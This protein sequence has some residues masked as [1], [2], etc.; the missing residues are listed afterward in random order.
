M[1]RKL[2]IEDGVL[3]GFLH[4]TY[5]AKKGG[6]A[7]TGNAVR[8]G[9]NGLPT[10][11]ITN[12]YIEKGK[13]TRY[14]LTADISN[15]IYITDTMGIHT[16]NPISGDFSVGVSGFWIKNGVIVH[17]VREAVFS[18]NIFDMLQKINDIG[19]D[20][21]FYGRIGSPSISLS[22]MDISGQ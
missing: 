11:G 1:R 12:F 22:E 3:K 20:L 17:P 10:V 6:T 7:S 9:I 13:R 14:P 16:A 18:G 19:D 8:G 15:G 5:T 2:L 21:R 4:N